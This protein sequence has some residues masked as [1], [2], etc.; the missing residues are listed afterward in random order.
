M[1]RRPVLSLIVL[2]L[3][4]VAGMFLAGT[5]ASAHSQGDHYA[6][7]WQGP[8]RD[9]NWSFTAN[10]PTGERRDR[11]SEAF[12]YWTSLGELNYVRQADGVTFDPT[13]GCAS[14]PYNSVHWRDTGGGALAYVGVCSYVSNQAIASATMVFNSKVD[15]HTAGTPAQNSGTLVPFVGACLAG[16]CPHDLAGVA[17]HEAGHFTGFAGPFQAGHFDGDSAM[18]EERQRHTMCPAIKPGENT[19]RSLEEHDQHTYRNAYPY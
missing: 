17:V 2:T 11:V 1:T 15:W 18:C 6:K 10:Y 12:N 19:W 3:S 5:V 13:V 8:V 4:A 14:R 16:R 9:I 7:R